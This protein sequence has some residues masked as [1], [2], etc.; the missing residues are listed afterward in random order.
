[1]IGAAQA[2]PS[3]VLQDNYVLAFGGHAQF[4]DLIDPDD[5]GAVNANEH[6]RIES[7]FENLDLLAQQVCFPPHLQP[8]K[9]GI[10][11]DPFHVRRA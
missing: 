8:H 7:A 9:V 10:G 2:Q 6:P 4:L 11:F 1:M 3:A 5:G